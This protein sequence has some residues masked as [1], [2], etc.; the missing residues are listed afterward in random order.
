MISSPAPY[1]FCEMDGNLSLQSSQE[2]KDNLDEATNKADAVTKN[3][4]IFIAKVKDIKYKAK[5]D[6]VDIEK[7]TDERNSLA[8][9]SNFLKTTE[10]RTRKFPFNKV[11]MLAE[12]DILLLF[13]ILI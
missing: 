13:S 6:D 10:R 9:S 1:L 3:I 4:D 5:V 8:M 7:L 2:A 12:R 11:S